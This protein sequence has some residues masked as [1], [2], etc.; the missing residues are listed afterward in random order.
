VRIGG[1]MSM[2]IRDAAINRSFM[3]RPPAVQIRWMQNLSPTWRR[4][5]NKVINSETTR[6]YSELMKVIHNVFQN[7][8]LAASKRPVKPRG[9]GY[10]E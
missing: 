8:D 5:L 9:S 6:T 7:S 4:I 10:G 1:P 2:R 3:D